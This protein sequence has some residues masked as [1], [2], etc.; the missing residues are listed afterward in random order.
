MA[1]T[2]LQTFLATISRMELWDYGC[3]LLGDFEPL[4]YLPHNSSVKRSSAAR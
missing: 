2:D 1:I 3:Y 4:E